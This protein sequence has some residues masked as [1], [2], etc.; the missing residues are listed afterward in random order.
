M[1]VFDVNTGVVQNLSTG[2]VASWTADDSTVLSQST[3]NQ[4]PRFTV[5]NTLSRVT[6]ERANKPDN[7]PENLQGT[8]GTSYTDTALTI[9]A[10]I[11]LSSYPQDDATGTPNDHQLIAQIGS[12]KLLVTSGGLLKV[13][14]G[15]SLATVTST[16]VVPCSRSYVAVS[17]GTSNTVF[18]VNGQTETVA[19][20]VG[21]GASGT[22]ISIG[23]LNTGAHKAN[24]HFYWLRL[25][26]SAV[27]TSLAGLS[28][29]PMTS[30][31]V[32]TNPSRVVVLDG[33]SIAE[34]VAATNLKNLVDR[35]SAP[36]ARGSNWRWYNNA[37]FGSTVTGATS[38]NG[39]RSARQ[40][41][42]A[43]QTKPVIL[44]Y[45]VGINDLAAAPSSYQTYYDDLIT[46]L[47][48]DRTIVPTL[49]S[50]ICTVLPRGQAS[51]PSGFAANRLLY[52]TLIR[53]NAATNRYQVCDF[54]ADDDFAGSSSSD[55][56][57]R[58][59]RQGYSNLPAGIEGTYRGSWSGLT[60]SYALGD[61]VLHVFPDFPIWVTGT[62][63]TIGQVRFD[64]ANSKI[65]RATTNHTSDATNRPTGASGASN[66]S[67]LDTTSYVQCLQDHTSSALNS[68]SESGGA[69]IWGWMTADG[70]HPIDHGFYELANRLSN[71]L[72]TSDGALVTLYD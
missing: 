60:L 9:E 51:T 44:I 33:D 10:V 16:L 17:C 5:Q 64:T 8:S 69:S 31:L 13:V 26:N 39:R 67:L 61:R 11:A 20:V 28:S 22:A 55:N 49:S 53:T 57:D 2:Q 42:L 21:T 35:L 6:F 12:I 23:S 7:Q 48:S 54:A 68:P 25:T 72:P 66:W 14:R 32:P 29:L 58:V 65:Y 36:G 52:N 24:I 38:L 37:K 46:E 41:I 43:A 56:Q 47:T 3:E 4:K 19:S 71:V 70:V 63:Y 40:A 27:G 62:S 30:K 50:I 59:S 18:C 45:L 34:G 1:A 15:S